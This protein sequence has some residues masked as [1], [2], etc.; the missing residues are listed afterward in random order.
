MNVY[1][2]ASLINLMI[3]INLHHVEIFSLEKIEWEEMLYDSGKLSGAFRLV[4]VIV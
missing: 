4:G 2:Y 3:L 1:I